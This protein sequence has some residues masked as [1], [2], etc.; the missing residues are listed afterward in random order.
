MI[1][2]NNMKVYSDNNYIAIDSFSREGQAFKVIDVVNAVA[3]RG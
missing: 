3:D 2:D 1:A